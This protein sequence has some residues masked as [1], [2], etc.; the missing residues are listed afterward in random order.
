MS[1]LSVILSGDEKE[2]CNHI[3]D[4]KDILD[5]CDYQLVIISNTIKN[6]DTKYEY[7]IYNYTESYNNFKDFCLSL[8]KYDRVLI[9]EKGIELNKSITDRIKTY[10][11]EESDVNLQCNFKMYIN[12]DKFFLQE[13]TLIYNTNSNENKQLNTILNDYSFLFQYDEDIEASVYKLIN[14]KRYKELYEWTREF[15]DDIKMKIYQHIEKQKIDLSLAEINYIEEEFFKHDLHKKYSKYL[16]IK[17]LYKNYR[18]TLKGSIINAV[19]ESEFSSEDL[20]FSLFLLETF[21]KNILIMDILSLLDNDTRVSYLKYLFELDE[22]FYLK[23]YGF[24]MNID[25]PKELDKTNNKNIEIYFDIIKAYIICMS[26]KSEEIEK[27]E[28]LIQMFTDYTNCGLYLLEKSS[29]TGKEAEFLSEIGK[30][31]SKLSCDI[32]GAIEILKCASEK[33]DLMTLSTRY[34]IQKLVCENNLY[35]SKLSI[36]MIVKNEETNIERCLKSL[37]PLVDKKLA[38]IILVDTGSTDNTVEIAGKFL[39]KTYFHPWS[40]S[41]SEAR[42]WSLSLA[43]GEY[44]FI[45]DGDDEIKCEDMNEIIKEF[46]NDEYKKYNTFSVK[47]KSY[48]TEEKD[49]YST[50]TQ[51]HIFKNDG[52]FHYSGA[53]HNQPIWRGPIKHL[54]ISIMHYGYIMTAEVSEKKFNRT[55]PLLKKELERNFNNIYKSIYY[56]YQLASSYNMHKDYKEALDEVNIYLRIVKD[57]WNSIKDN[58]NITYN[59]LAIM[60]YMNNELYDEAL[61]L[62]NKSLKLCKDF[63]DFIYYKGKILFIKKMY[64]ESIECME[65]YLKVLEKFS[66]L[67]I[68]QD[69]KY[70]FYTLNLDKEVMLRIINAYYQ[71]KDYKSCLKYINKISDKKILQQIIY[72]VF[73]C[74]FRGKEYQKLIQLYETQIIPENYDVFNYFI[75]KNIDDLPRE[76]QTKFINAVINSDMDS[77]LINILDTSAMDIVKDDFHKVLHILDKYDIENIDSSGAKAILELI[78]PIAKQYNYIKYNDLIELKAFKRCIKFILNRTLNLK[79]FDMF[80]DEK[81]LELLDKYINV[82]LT[83][84]NL[85]AKELLEEREYK[86]C[87]YI[88]K[89]HEELGRNDLLSAVRYIKDAVNEDK[90]M[91]RPMELYLKEILPMNEI[92]TE[93]GV[94][95]NM[96]D[97]MKRYSK[98]VKR[99]IEKLINQGST[100]EAVKLIEEYEKIIPNDVEVCSM[101]AIALIMENNF[102]AAKDVLLDGLKTDKNDF[103]L[104]YNLAYVY[105][106]LN[107]YNNCVR[108]YVKAKN[109]CKDESISNEIENKIS[110]IKSEHKDVIK[111]RIIFFVKP[112]MDSFLDDIINGLTREYETK[113]VIVNNYN[114]IDEGMEWADICWFEWCD[115]LTI[116]GS[117]L[118]VSNEKK[119]VCRIHGYEVYTNYIKQTIW[120]N[121]DQLII[122]APHIR[123]IFEENTKDIDKGTLRVDTIFCG[124]NTNKYPMNKKNKGFNLGYLGYINFKKNIPLTLDIF[125]RLYDKDNRYKLYLAGQFQDERTLA[126][127]KYFIKEYNLQNNI[128]FDGWQNDIQKIEWLEKI[129]YMI[130]SSIDE[131]LC[132]AA[133]E[134]MCSG[135]KPILHNCEGIKDHYDKR[136]IFNTVD[137][138]VEMIISKEY[139]SNEYRKFIKENYSLEKE[140]CKLKSI[141]E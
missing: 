53:V 119:I 134:A 135:I 60:I 76:E 84:I 79:Q 95:E 2:I 115:E 141:L 21:N 101:K 9:V 22:K 136:Y 92:T 133:A 48:F 103:D 121:I 37:K 105:E 26:G 91:A 131:G 102:N 71:L 20:Y 16:K 124:I 65:E 80:T 18:E 25:L 68:A 66:S 120:R 112:E 38:E 45:V 72:I 89:A 54:N 109:N 57:N 36:C 108:A 10:I 40:G 100:V 50:I 88:L 47:V 140:Y 4:I 97:E 128:F 77:K 44:I 78:V 73:E 24:M 94:S 55:V 5:I 52:Y 75:K 58:Y 125:K 110:K 116:Y 56:R 6:I 83:L 35:T 63:I 74:Y 70:V 90:E 130:I 106:N 96:D 14:Y 118:P 62:C 137:E 12:K 132:F 87:N 1:N 104:L 113:K 3:K 59:T 19:K 67:S 46:S 33:F 7:V 8:C 43:T 82:C 114:Q 81:I 32:K 138:A 123:R 99:S 39:E 42:N 27:K 29:I 15:T 51:N 122:V 69:D 111:K 85:G 49:G 64:E 98:E 28:K 117:S 17:N 129:D 34:Y 139:N 30:A 23:I 13:D 41:F 107:D 126:Y 86:F 93:E 11:G 61:N 31:A 127:F